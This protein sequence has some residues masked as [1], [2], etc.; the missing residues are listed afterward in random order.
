M[1]GYGRMMIHNYARVKSTY[2]KLHFGLDDEG[3]PL[4]E[5]I[6]KTKALSIA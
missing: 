2:R 6:W 5:Y 3:S 1:S 4:F